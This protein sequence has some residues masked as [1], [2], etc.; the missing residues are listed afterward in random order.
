MLKTTIQ[1]NQ[2][3]QLNQLLT[4]ITILPIKLKNLSDNE[5]L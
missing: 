1:L 4:K 5:A 3:I 2:Q